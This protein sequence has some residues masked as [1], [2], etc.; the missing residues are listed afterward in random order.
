MSW[1]ALANDLNVGA[2]QL[3]NLSRGGRVEVRFL[4]TLSS[5]LG[6]SAESHA[7]ITGA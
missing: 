4:L 5:W 6:C 3:T 2:S 1:Q 7:H